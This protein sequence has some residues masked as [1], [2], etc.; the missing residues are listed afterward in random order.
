MQFTYWK[1]DKNVTIGFLG[2]HK[3]YTSLCQMTKCGK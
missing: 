2:K 1:T 3:K